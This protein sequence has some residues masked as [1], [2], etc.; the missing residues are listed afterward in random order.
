MIYDSSLYE[1]RRRNTG[2]CHLSGN[3]VGDLINFFITGGDETKL[4]ASEDSQSVKVSD[5]TGRKNMKRRWQ[6][7]TRPFHCIKLAV[8]QVILD[9][10]PPFYATMAVHWARS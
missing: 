10:L 6:T 8:W 1:L 2:L 7:A 9:T 4:L 3:N 5:A